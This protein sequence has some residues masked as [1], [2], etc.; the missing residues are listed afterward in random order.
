MT[1][2]LAPRAPEG[3]KSDQ[4]RP[5]T[6]ETGVNLYAE[7]SAL[8]KA[9][10]THVLCTASVEESVPGW[11][12][13]KGQGWVTAEYSMLPGSTNPRKSRDRGVKI[14]GRTTEIHSHV[15]S[16][17][18][19]GRFQGG[20]RTSKG[21]RKIEILTLA[22]LA[23]RAD[24]STWK[25]EKVAGTVRIRIEGDVARFSDH[26]NATFLTRRLR[27]ENAEHALAVVS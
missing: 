22:Q 3:R 10:N 11:L 23:H 26:Q 4:I 27:R 18:T 19:V 6:I 21:D 8:I 20:H 14:D 25:D 16:V 24:V 13:G 1:R 5:L 7:G 15:H 2:E 17:S 12:K 9:G